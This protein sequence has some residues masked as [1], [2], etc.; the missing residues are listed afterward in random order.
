LFAACL[1]Q[2]VERAQP[3][4]LPSTVLFRF[5]RNNNNCRVAHCI[6]PSSLCTLLRL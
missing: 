6:P 1:S 5:P 4:K 2:K 3:G